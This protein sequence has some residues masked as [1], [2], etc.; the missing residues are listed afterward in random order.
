MT[1]KNTDDTAIVKASDYDMDE[2]RAGEISASFEP[3]LAE[4]HLIAKEYEA[5]IKEEIDK[6]VSL[7][8]RFLRLQLVKVRT[9]IAEAHRTQKHMFLKAGQFVDAWKNASTLPVAQ[10]EEKLTE[11]E[12]HFENIERE[13]VARIRATRA[14]EL[15][16]Y[17]V[18]GYM[19][20][21]HLGQMEDIVYANY[22]AGVK[23]ADRL[24]Q[25][26]YEKAE[27]ERIAKEK[28]EAA[29]RERVRLENEQ[30]KKEAADRE[31]AEQARLKKEAKE[32][33]KAEVAAKAERLAAEA[34]LKVEREAREQQEEAAR[35]A[36]EAAEAK[37]EAEREASAAKL[38]V[39]RDE[40]ER[41]EREKKEREE[42][43]LKAR[44]ELE[45]REKNKARRK[46][47][48]EGIRDA[49]LAIDKG[50]NHRITCNNIA[51][52][53]VKGDIPNVTVNY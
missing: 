9:G 6:D 3:M 5:I 44:K 7:R 10:M 16:T 46:T 14:E 2:K 41:L 15:W 35:K 20:P 19:M 50:A 38:K 25:E 42:A 34:K 43:E 49:L 12:D 30:L 8:A 31:K 52:A 4:R 1:A 36:S 23:E 53:L 13:R 27:E 33:E 24:R 32:R 48:D 40:R 51:R 47:V 22:L 21:A 18:T 17:G 39:E 28:A 29:E 37:L 45:A 26:A 11:I